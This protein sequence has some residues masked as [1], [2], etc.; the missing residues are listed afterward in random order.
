MLVTSARKDSLR[1]QKLALVINGKGSTSWRAWPT[2][3][4][5]DSEQTGTRTGGP[6]TLTSVVRSWP[7]PSARLDRAGED[8]TRPQRPESA[9][10]GEDLTTV[11]KQWQT[12]QVDSF[13]SR[14]GDRKDEMGLDQEARFWGTPRMTDYKGAGQPGDKAHDHRLRRQYLDAQATVFPLSPLPDSTGPDGKPPSKQHLVLSP[15]FVEWLMGFPIE[16]TVLRPS[17]I[18]SY[19][20]WLR[21][22]GRLLTEILMDGRRLPS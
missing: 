4:A 7:T 1:R 21:L 14:S 6:D 15:W 19:R 22:H 13:R 18:V 2:A 20:S 16:L 11:A 9:G 5:E 3:V 8:R 10:H 12:P 17:E